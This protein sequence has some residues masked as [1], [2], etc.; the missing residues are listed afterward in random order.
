MTWDDKLHDAFEAEFAALERAVQTELLAVAKLLGEYGPQ[1]GRPYVD[2]LN[3][4]KHANMKEMRF[5][6]ADGEWRVA[7]AFDPERNAIVLVAGDKSGGSQK[8]FYK[9][10]I[11]KAD[12]RFSGHLENLKPAKKG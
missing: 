1:L 9:Q 4:S 3:G 6:A 11:A 8:R 12:S 2:T 10:L 7:F 5:S